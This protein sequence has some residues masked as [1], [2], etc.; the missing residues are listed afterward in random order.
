MRKGLIVLGFLFLGVSNLYAEALLTKVTVIVASNQG[1]DID[2]END[3]YRDQLIKLFSYTSYQQTNQYSIRLEEGKQES[4]A[5]S[6]GYEL[7][8]SLY[9]KEKGRNVIRTMIQKDGKQVLNSELSLTGTGPVFL[10]GPPIES[11][12]LLLVIESLS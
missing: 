5:I 2:L 6:G 4:L 12:D 10:G 9:K 1:S 8:L 3:A 11:G 7:I